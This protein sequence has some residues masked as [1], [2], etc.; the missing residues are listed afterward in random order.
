MSRESQHFLYFHIKIF[1]EVSVF[2]KKLIV[3]LLCVLEYERRAEDDQLVPPD[4]GRGGE[5][6]V[7]QRDAERHVGRVPV[8]L[9]G[10]LLL[11]ERVQARQ[12]GFPT[13]KARGGTEKIKTILKSRKNLDGV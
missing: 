5:P 12:Q 10:R 11:Q 13:G 3:M 4:G 1:V 9:L 2:W 8:R 6:L 7:L